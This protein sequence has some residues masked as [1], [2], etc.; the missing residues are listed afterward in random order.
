[1]IVNYICQNIYVEQIFIMVIRFY[2]KFELF[3]YIAFLKKIRNFNLLFFLL[4]YFIIL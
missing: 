3:E 2:Y 4:I 1:M